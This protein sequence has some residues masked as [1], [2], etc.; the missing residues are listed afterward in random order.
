M[1]AALAVVKEAAVSTVELIQS[2]HGVLRRVT[3]HYVQQNDNASLV[4]R[5]YQFLELFRCTVSTASIL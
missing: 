5:V 3:V 1:R 2:V 4:R